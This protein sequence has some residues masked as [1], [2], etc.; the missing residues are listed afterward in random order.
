MTVDP[1]RL[2]GD[3]TEEFAE[4]LH[5]ATPDLRRD[6]QSLEQRSERH[7]RGTDFV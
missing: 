2:T 1:L 5:K 4:V 3:D 7:R 6:S